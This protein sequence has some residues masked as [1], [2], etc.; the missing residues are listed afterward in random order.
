MIKRFKPFTPCWKRK[1]KNQ[2]NV[3]RTQIFLTELEKRSADFRSGKNKAVSWKDAKAQILSYRSS[4][5][6]K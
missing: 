4:A 1:L 3:E 2:M 6:K 5:K